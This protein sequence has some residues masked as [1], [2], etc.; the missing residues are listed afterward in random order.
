MKKKILK[1][2]RLAKIAQAKDLHDKIYLCWKGMTAKD[3]FS[4]EMSIARD[5]FETRHIDL[6][7]LENRVKREL[8]A[9]KV[10]LNTEAE[11][12][13]IKSAENRLFHFAWKAAREFKP[14]MFEKLARAMRRF[15]RHKFPET[16]DG[17][18][19]AYL[20]GNNGNVTKAVKCIHW[21]CDP[22]LERDKLNRLKKT[23]FPK[24]T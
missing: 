8:K 15:K 20:V 2:N 12:G 3:F 14:E 23:L 4:R 19:R 21:N 6:S 24:D 17:W 16:R 11:W 5:F 9:A 10:T 7:E 22:D 13:T 1:R 18:R